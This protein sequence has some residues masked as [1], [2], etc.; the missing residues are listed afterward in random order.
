M[1]SWLQ[2]PITPKS[3][4]GKGRDS[5]RNPVNAVRTIGH[6]LQ[7][8]FSARN[9]ASHPPYTGEWTGPAG[10]PSHTHFG[11][12][13]TD[14]HNWPCSYG[15]GKW[16]INQQW[17]LRRQICTSWGTHRTRG[18]TVPA[19]TIIIN[20]SISNPEI[21]KTVGSHLDMAA[22]HKSHSQADTALFL[23]QWERWSSLIPSSFAICD[24][25]AA[26]ISSKWV[27]PFKRKMRLVWG[28][29][30]RAAVPL[31]ELKS[32]KSSYHTISLGE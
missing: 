9:L 30:N 8:K 19:S 28:I 10:L 21:S 12:E 13:R 15:L 7:D 29:F 26:R 6:G 17:L 32:I 18:W 5:C 3:G 23:Y 24:G 22:L 4:N 27:K 20:P 11:E 25:W 31:S 2:K 16:G 1:D 14:C